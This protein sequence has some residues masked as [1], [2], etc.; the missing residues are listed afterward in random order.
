MPCIRAVRAALSTAGSSGTVGYSAGESGLEAGKSG[1]EAGEFSLAAGE[2]PCRG[3][4]HSTQRIS[5]RWKLRLRRFHVALPVT[6]AVVRGVLVSSFCSDSGVTAS[7]AFSTVL[8]GLRS[9]KHLQLH[10]QER[11]EDSCSTSAPHC[12]AISCRSPLPPCSVV[13]VPSGATMSDGAAGVANLATS[14]YSSHNI[15]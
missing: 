6:V 4:F 8:W 10:P 2:S 12:S 9:A 1:S 13:D 5:C 14:E 15:S 11:D 7:P 3:R